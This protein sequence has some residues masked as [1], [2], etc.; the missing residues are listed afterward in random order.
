MPHFPLRILLLT[1]FGALP[2]L[3]PVSA[4]Q[5]QVA[6][7]AAPATKGGVPFDLQ[8]L[9]K[10]PAVFPAAEAPAEGVKSFFFEGPTYQGKPTRVF[11]YYGAPPKDEKDPGKRFPAMVL[12]HGG[13]GTAFDRWVKV[14]NARGY[15]AIAMD[16][17]GCVPV[18]S[19]GKWQRHD[20]GGPPGWDAS[21]GQLETP[22]QDQ[23]THQAVSSVALA[24]SLIRSYPEVDPD[25]I[26]VTGISWGGYLTS[27]VAG[28]DSRFQLAVPVYGCGFLG[29]N[30]VWVPQFEKLG[31]EKAN[32]WLT[33][34]DPSQYLPQ[35]KM[36]ILWVNG[37]N[38][39]AYPMD[40]WQKSYRLSQ[41]TRSLCLRI[42]MPHGHGPVGEN[43]EEIHIFANQILRKE[44]PLAKIVDQGQSATEAWA[45]FQAEVP[46]VKAELSFTRD[47]G[48]WQDRKWEQVP[49]E[50]DAAAKGVVAKI[51]ADAKVFYINLFD[52]RDCVISTEHVER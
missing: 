11:A 33:Q 28:V 51:P 9:S 46:I 20:Q 42:R 7:A 36:P 41:G 39:F 23:W 13:G 26:G 38:D 48:R 29:D 18:G 19:Y 3:V 2:L 50:I 8:A 31:K 22:V 37:T 5:A 30:S 35:A 4:A 12:I 14:W 40:S 43:P 32:L 52:Q 1:L 45:T 21:F 34:W 15:A 47:T 6:A 49:A 10:V 16:L 24:H 25:R 44:K 27:I 17:C